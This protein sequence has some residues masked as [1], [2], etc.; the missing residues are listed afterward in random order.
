MPDDKRTR[1]L[2]ATWACVARAG[3]HGVTTAAIA[4]EARV[5]TG[6]F[7][8]YFPGKE[9]VLDA[10]LHE[11]TRRLTGGEGTR[12]PAAPAEWLYHALGERWESWAVNAAAHPGAFAY[13]AL[14]WHTPAL[15]RG[16]EQLPFPALRRLDQ[17]LAHRRGLA[18][19]EGRALLGLFA[20][21]WEGAVRWLRA[22]PPDAGPGRREAVLTA[23]F[24]A[25]WALTGLP[26]DTPLATDLPPTEPA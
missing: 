9:A 24:E 22:L 10:A 17:V 8:T 25:W 16:A 2:E 7:F 14:Y 19:A 11:A 12:G 6:T 18:P 3:F 15:P 20:W 1:L 26:K 23:A 13:W 21:H 4:R 5:A